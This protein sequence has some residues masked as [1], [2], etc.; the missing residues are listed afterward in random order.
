[1]REE[2]FVSAVLMCPL[3]ALM[4][5]VAQ[6]KAHRTLRRRWGKAGEEVGRGTAESG[7]SKRGLLFR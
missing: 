1:M 2:N 5:A 7:G 4:R 6:V 3:K